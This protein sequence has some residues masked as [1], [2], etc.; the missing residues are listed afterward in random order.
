VVT[1]TRVEGRQADLMRELATLRGE[2]Q[3]ELATRGHSGLFS[4]IRDSFVGR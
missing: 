1:P 2:E 4:R 3:A